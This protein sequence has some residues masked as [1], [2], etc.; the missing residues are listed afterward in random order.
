MKPL[1]FIGLG[2][3]LLCASAFGQLL[4][5]QGDVTANQTD[6]QAFPFR[7]HG[8]KMVIKLSAT[9]SPGTVGF[10]LRSPGGILI[11][12]QAAGV[13]TMDRWLVAGSNSGIYNLEIVPHRTAGHWTARIDSLPGNSSI[14]AQAFSGVLMML[15]AFTGVL[16]WRKRT[17]V[18]WR[19]FWAGAGIWTVGVL[20]KFAFAWPLNRVFMGT[21]GHHTGLGLVVGSIYCG[22]MTGVFEI[23]VTLAAVLIWRRL[24]A[25][26]QRA[27]AVGLGAGA[28]EALLLGLAA[29]IGSL[30]ALA[31]GQEDLVLRSLSALSASTPLLWLAGPAERVIA[32][33][34]HTASRVLVLR[35]VAGRA[36]A[37]FWAGF[38]WLSALD[39]VAGAVLLTG[40]TASG[41]LWRVEL[42]LLPFG[43]LSVPLISRAIANWPQSVPGLETTE[44]TK[45][46]RRLGEGR[47]DIETLGRET[48]KG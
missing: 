8:G 13:F 42:I 17:A 29:A 18:Q 6:A 1:P 15:V 10:D 34:A 25:D 37:G 35:A 24:A 38:A 21:H 11:G 33:A 41:C 2:A 48:L 32:I 5:V 12:R 44:E 39:L 7:F 23:G 14:Y 40:L 3:H 36:W 45:G 46:A 9:T 28:F 16:W 4:E 43:I 30:A 47:K 27:V 26:P 19:W 31:V 22:L 20:L